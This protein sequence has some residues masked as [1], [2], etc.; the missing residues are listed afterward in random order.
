MLHTQLRAWVITLSV[1]PP[2]REDQELNLLCPVRGL[3]IYIE[4]SSPVRQ[5]EQLFLC[6]GG[7]TKRSLVTKQRIS[8]WLVDAIALAYSSL[9]LQYPIGVTAYSNRPRLGRGL[10]VCP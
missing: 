1:L 4:R 3:R 2:S 8:R 10:A 7:R 5:S 9:G 6:F